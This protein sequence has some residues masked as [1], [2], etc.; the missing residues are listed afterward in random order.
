MLKHQPPTVIR[1]WSMI[2]GK[3]NW[4]TNILAIDIFIVE[5]LVP[6]GPTLDDNNQGHI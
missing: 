5:D 4:K 3:E 1:N 2:S 6:V